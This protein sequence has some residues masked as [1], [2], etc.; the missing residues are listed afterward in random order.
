VEFVLFILLI[1]A[2]GVGLLFG[3]RMERRWVPDNVTGEERRRK[4]WV[5]AAFAAFWVV[6][7]GVLAFAGIKP[8]LIL[9]G[10]VFG[11]LGLW[12]WSRA[13]WRG[14]KAFRH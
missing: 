3:T 7:V 12:S 1:S 8:F 11:V 4:Q 14:R 6:S 5:L 2:A 13:L 10:V 9:T